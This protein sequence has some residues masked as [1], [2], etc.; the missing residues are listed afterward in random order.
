MERES[1]LVSFAQDAA[2]LLWA[3]LLWLVMSLP[4]VTCG[5][6]SCALYYTV[7]KVVRGKRGTVTKA[8]FHSFRQNLKQGSIA[9]ALLLLLVLTVWNLMAAFSGSP[10][11]ISV[12][13]S[14]SAL[15]LAAAP[16]FLL[17]P[18][19]FPVISRMEQSMSGQLKMAFYL[20]LKNL[21]LTIVLLLLGGLIILILW[22]MPSLILVFPGIYAFQSSL[23]LESVLP[24]MGTSF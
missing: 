9:S 16:L 24:K 14:L 12:S 23:L 11:G 13:A 8:F 19:L 18:F 1:A 4:L 3:G 6:A 17:L 21:P 10:A 15:L 2:D 7:V 5:A 20:S 22:Q